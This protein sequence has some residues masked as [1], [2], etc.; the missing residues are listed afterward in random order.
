MKPPPFQYCRPADL[1]EALLCLNKYGSQAR[2][3]A[4]GQSLVPEMNFRK[5]CPQVLIDINAVESLKSVERDDDFLILGAGLTQSELARCKP[6]LEV[7][8]I[9][10]DV[11]DYVGY[12]QTRNRGT[13]GGSLAYGDPAGELPAMAMALDAEFELKAHDRSRWVR[14]EAFYIGPF[15]TVI[16]P[17]EMLARIRI[18]L[19]RDAV[20][21][22]FAE[23]PV[24]TFG[25]A[26]A[27]VVTALALDSG[28]TVSSA[29]IVAWGVGDRPLRLNGVEAEL[30]GS[31]LDD[32]VI[33]AAVSKLQNELDP[34]GDIHASPAL[35][36]YLAGNLLR[37]SLQNLC[38]ESL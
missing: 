28:Y 22:A 13:F 5:T 2:I 33:C 18:P 32:S 23:Q 29:R 24:K 16:E 12:E 27:G 25:K 4:G 10:K 21:W 11:L 7:C 9:M 6:M 15:S 36:K 26:I 37:R 8:P 1:S 30:D 34:P 38:S 17:D 35:R 19:R 31:C 14:A 20:L 3:L